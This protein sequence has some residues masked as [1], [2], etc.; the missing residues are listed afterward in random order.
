MA[1]PD[2]VCFF[3][4]DF[5]QKKKEESFEVLKGIEALKFL[6]EYC[7]AMGTSIEI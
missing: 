6:L 1:T 5:F 7:R 3:K 4:S 2:N